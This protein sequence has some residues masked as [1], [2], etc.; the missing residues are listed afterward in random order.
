[1][2]KSKRIICWIPVAIFLNMHFLLFF[3]IF[4]LEL[5][6]FSFLL[7]PGN[8]TSKW[9]ATCQCCQT[10]AHACHGTAGISFRPL[11]TIFQLSWQ[12]PS[13]G[14]WLAAV[15][16]LRKKYDIPASAVRLC[17]S[18]VWNVAEMTLE[19]NLYEQTMPFECCVLETEQMKTQK[20]YL[21]FWNRKCIK[22]VKKSFVIKFVTS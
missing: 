10:Q 22:W 5:L 1:V 21:G 19:I 13:S 18:A 6:C 9:A 14:K 20:N 16:A 17:N 4:V 3:K 15:F 2:Y 11:N 12:R 8:W 7:V